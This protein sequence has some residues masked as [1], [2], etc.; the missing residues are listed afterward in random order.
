MV[1][2]RPAASPAVCNAFISFDPAS[3]TLLVKSTVLAV[4][5]LNLWT[6]SVMVPLRKRESRRRRRQRE[7][8]DSFKK[9]VRSATTQL[10]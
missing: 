5:R 10:L 2:I 7:Y 9:L 4:A 6:A 1:I 8:S 3:S